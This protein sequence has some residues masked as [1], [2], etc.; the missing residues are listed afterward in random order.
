MEVEH[1]ISLKND[2]NQLIETVENEDE[3]LV[4]KYRYIQNLTWEE[5]G[6]KLHADRT[7]VYRC[8]NKA[9]KNLNFKIDID[10]KIL[11]C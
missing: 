5:I 2:I 6:R 7:T 10:K 9:V 4:L 3:K 8:H 1:L 11:K